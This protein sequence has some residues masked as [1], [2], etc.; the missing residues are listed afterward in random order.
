[1]IAFYTILC[2]VDWTNMKWSFF[3][4][5]KLESWFYA[6]IYSSFNVLQLC[7]TLIMASWFLPA[8]GGL[9]GS[10]SPT[11]YHPQGKP[12]ESSG[13]LACNSLWVLFSLM[14]CL[15]IFWGINVLGC[16]LIKIKLLMVNIIWAFSTLL[17]SRHFNCNI[18]FVKYLS[19]FSICCRLH[20]FMDFTMNVYGSKFSSSSEDQVS[21]SIFR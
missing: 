7:G 18:K 15:F 19:D 6:V 21:H 14:C 20:K 13:I 1:M 16:N 4:F 10:L 5:L 12:W 8:F 2:S 9:E 17:K 3:F 11:N